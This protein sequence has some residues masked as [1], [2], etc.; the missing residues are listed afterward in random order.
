MHSIESIPTTEMLVPPEII[1][2]DG[3]PLLANF[4]PIPSSNSPLNYHPR[5]P[6]PNNRRISSKNPVKLVKC[7]Q[8]LSFLKSRIMTKFGKNSSS[9]RPP[10]NSP[11]ANHQLSVIYRK[12]KHEKNITGLRNPSK[13]RFFSKQEY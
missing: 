6:Y 8:S 10:K 7:V 11:T 1:G 2:I 13:A 9:L 3:N 12:K 5:N 4:R